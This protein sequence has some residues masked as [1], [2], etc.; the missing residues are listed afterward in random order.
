[1]TVL[2]DQ[3][4][5]HVFMTYSHGAVGEEPAPLKQ[6]SEGFCRELTREFNTDGGPERLKVFRDQD[7]RRDRS[8]DKHEP[9]DEAL[10]RHIEK[11]ALFLVLMSPQY[12]KSSWCGRERDH[13]LKCAENQRLPAHARTL[14][15]QVIETKDTWPEAFTLGGE[16]RVNTGRDFINPGNPTRPREW[17]L[18]KNE[19]GGAFRDE[20]VGLAGDIRFKLDDLAELMAEQARAEADRAKLADLAEPKK[21]YLHARK[22]H[23]TA[24]SQVTKVLGKQ[25]FYMTA[26]SPDPA[27]SDTKRQEKAKQQRVEDMIES[28]A[29]LL[30]GSDDPRTLDKDLRSIGLFDRKEARDKSNKRLPCAVIDTAN[31]DGAFEIV[32]SNAKTLRIDWLS[33]TPSELPDIHG[34]LKKKAI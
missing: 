11:S 34:W 20:L 12:L 18:P 1:M 30:L 23:E 16:G 9:L 10:E 24:W 4:Q 15:A 33:G 29:L 32:R 8:L 6:W 21:I 28:D 26:L 2:G 25:G 14:I 17:P 13:W 27:Y 22:D 7:N 31:L 3:F 19:S 5:H